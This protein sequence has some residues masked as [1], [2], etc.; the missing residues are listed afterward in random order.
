MENAEEPAFD[1][2]CFSAGIFN[3]HPIKT[4]SL[5]QYPSIHFIILYYEDLLNMS[6]LP[7]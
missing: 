3:K 1:G 2:E 7:D 5:I 4:L 6:N